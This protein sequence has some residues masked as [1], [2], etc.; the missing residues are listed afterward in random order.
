MWRVREQKGLA[1]KRRKMHEAEYAKSEVGGTVFVVCR[2]GRRTANPHD[3]CLTSDKLLCIWDSEEAAASYAKTKLFGQWTA[4]PADPVDFEL[5]AKLKYNKHRNRKCYRKMETRVKSK[6]TSIGCLV[7][8]FEDYDARRFAITSKASSENEFL[9]ELSQALSSTESKDW[10]TRLKEF[11]PLVVDMC[12]KY[13]GYKAESVH[14]RRE[15]VAGDLEMPKSEGS[16]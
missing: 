16:S 6:S 1:V 7:E 9:V 10:N 13:R 15:L 11:L 8:V 4:R 3:L 12:C 14:E 5:I 2:E